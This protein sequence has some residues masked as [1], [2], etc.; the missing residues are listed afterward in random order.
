MLR[1]LLFTVSRYMNDLCVPNP[2]LGKNQMWSNIHHIPSTMLMSAHWVV[3]PVLR[4]N[5]Q[6]VLSLY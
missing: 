6:Y 1:E 3:G 2:V 4:G 5:T